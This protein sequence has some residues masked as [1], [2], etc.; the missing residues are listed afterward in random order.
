[1]AGG[2]GGLKLPPRVGDSVLNEEDLQHAAQE[3]QCDVRAIK[4][5]TAVEAPRGAFDEWAR[6][7]ILFERHLFHR[8]TGGTHDHF[9]PDIS[10][11]TMGGYGR[12]AAQYGRLDRAYALDATAS[13]RAASWGAFQILGDNYARSG[14]GTVDLFVTAMCQSVQ[15]QLAAFVAYI[16]FSSAMAH[17]LQNKQWATFASMYNGPAYRRN[18]YDTNLES[19]Y[20][21]ARP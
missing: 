13:L 9:A 17:S 12:Y 20:D 18:H 2:V 3:L 14:F 6:P 8:F 19:A 15:Q 11:P 10:N 21:A 5:V 4:A 1:M 16:K 7:T